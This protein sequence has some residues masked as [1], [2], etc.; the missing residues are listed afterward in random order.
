LKSPVTAS[1]FT[2]VS[3]V[4][5]AACGPQVSGPE[6]DGEPMLDV[7]QMRPVGTAIPRTDYHA[8][9]KVDCSIDGKA[10]DGGC[11]AGVVRGWG[12][13]G[14]SLVDITRPDGLKRAIFVGPDGEPFGVDSTEADGTAGIDFTVTRNG[15]MVIVELGAERYSWPDTFVSAEQS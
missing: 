15:D 14:S 2:I 8:T 4:L 6:D 9:A 3:T 5:L 10:V 7:S 12:A 13:D 11:A 1:Y